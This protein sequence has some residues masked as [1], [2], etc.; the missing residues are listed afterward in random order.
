ME[1][2]HIRHLIPYLDLA[3]LSE[4]TQS[5]LSEELK[6]K[7]VWFQTPVK[8]VVSKLSQAKILYI[9]PDGYDQWTDIL[10]KLHQHR[11]LPVKLIVLADSDYTFG[12][13]HLEAL[14]ALFPNTHFWVQNWCGDLE[15]VKLLPI[16]VNATYCE[17]KPKRKVLGIS[18]FLN[19]E[20][21]VHREEYAEF[22]QQHPE[23]QDYTI[24]RL[25]YPDYCE[26]LSECYFSL[27]PMGAGYDTYR[28]WESLM[29]GCIP[30]VKKHPFFEVLRLQYPA[31]PFVVVEEWSDLLTLLP[32]LGEQ[33]YKDWMNSADVSCLS[34]DTW[35]NALQERRSLPTLA[36]N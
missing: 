9:H 31:L 3:L 24:P 6:A 18:F 4:E 2:F 14:V 7:A 23:L 22:L 33:T 16:G 35:L 8:E 30:I 21:F 26:A 32:L 15:R 29:M 36:E 27:C 25:G 13:E 11:P 5:T 12:N 28:F 19:Y 34:W 10:L 17:T 1:C 20:G